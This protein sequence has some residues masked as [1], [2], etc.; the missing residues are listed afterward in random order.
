M[1]S[2][3]YGGGGAGV[4]GAPPTSAAAAGSGEK[5]SLRQTWVTQYSKAVQADSWGDVV[6]AQDSYQAMAA[7]MAAKQGQVATTSLER[8]TMHRLVLCLSAR[9]NALK[10]MKES[11]VI[12]ATDMKKLQ[13]VFESL[14]T[15]QEP[16][17][18]GFPVEPVKFQTANPVRPST[19]GEIICGDREETYSDF[20]SSRAALA[21]VNGTVVSIKV[22]KIGLKD[23]QVYI[24]PTMTVLVADPKGN[25]L[26]T[27]DTPAATEKRVTHVI[28]G[29]TVYL[30]ISLEDMQRRNAAIF[31]E[32]KHYKPKKKKVS[33]RCWCFME[34]NELRKD[35]EILLEIYHKPTD[36]KK[37]KLSLHSEK[38]LYLH[39]IPS[40]I[41]P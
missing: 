27:H 25:I 38:Q 15:G 37:K 31:F 24:D 26:D 4:W 14:F 3:G 10:T 34:L 36:L 41:R 12:S 11:G 35:E 17:P 40:F 20:Q 2:G 13:P 5:D 6:E 32:F 21:N 19:E 22:D 39:L 8:D 29:T 33:T 16:S 9:V 23:A 7:I 1:A 18:A 30:N 28:F